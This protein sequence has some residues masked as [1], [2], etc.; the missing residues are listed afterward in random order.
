M[1]RHR[2]PT[3]D[4]DQD[5]TLRYIEEQFNRLEYAAWQIR[6]AAIELACSVAVGGDPVK[7]NTLLRAC[8]LG[9]VYDSSPDTLADDLRR[10]IAEVLH[11]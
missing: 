10:V 5:I 2:T 1:I 11:G 9:G 6:C 3:L 4:P 7:L 8:I